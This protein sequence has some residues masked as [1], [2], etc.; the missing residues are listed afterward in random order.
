[1]R[2]GD[3]S[4]WKPVNFEIRSGGPPA[5]DSTIP[6]ANSGEMIDLSRIF[7]DRV[8]QIFNNHYL[9]PRSPYCSLQI[10]EQGIGN[11]AS[12]TQ[13]AQI[14]DS[15][16]RRAAGAAGVLKLAGGIQFRT[17][18]DT[19]AKNI[20]FTS[21]W[22]NYPHEIVVPLLGSA[23]HAYLLMAGS[24]NP[25]ET[26]IDNGEVVVS[27]ADGTAQ[28]VALRNPANWWP[29]EQDYFSDDYAFRR[30]GEMPVR[31][32]LGTGKEYFP[33][34]FSRP[35]GGA[36]TVIDFAID[37]GRPLKSVTIRALSNTVVIGL[38]SVTLER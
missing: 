38:M 8:T 35:R 16:L 30:E 25:M 19:H 13:T 17:P 10:P 18:G 27:F 11:W 15:G 3:L 1:V 5:A 32:C 14:D 24:T 29:I 33:H 21:R 7:N 34:G 36:A 12:F 20:A 31:V 22:D 9:S 2:Q 28:R 26:E 37:P 6:A 4:W 23:R